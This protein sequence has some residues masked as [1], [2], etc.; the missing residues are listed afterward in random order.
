MIMKTL[1]FGFLG[2]G[3]VPNQ[4]SA[5]YLTHHQQHFFDGSDVER[6]VFET[7]ALTPVPSKN[8]KKLFWAFASNVRQ[9]SDG[10]TATLLTNL[11]GNTPN[12]SPFE[13]NWAREYFSNSGWD[14]EVEDVNFETRGLMK[15]NYI[16]CGSIKK[17]KK[18]QGFMLRVTA[19]GNVVTARRYQDIYNL[20]SCI[21]NHETNGY[22]AVGQTQPRKNGLKDA[23]YVNVKKNLKPSCGLNMTGIFPE[24]DFFGLQQESGF[25][26]VIPYSRKGYQLYAAVGETASNSFSDCEQNSDVLVALVHEGCEVRWVNR[27]GSQGEPALKKTIAERGLSIAQFDTSE[28]GLVITGKTTATYGCDDIAFD[29][30]LIFKLQEDGSIVNWMGHYSVEHDVSNCGL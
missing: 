21:P 4:A 22:V 12:T 29:N 3:L 14:L 23:V 10:D 2:L 5:Q 25:N 24:Q 30:I 26:K 20:K 11:K 27:Y 19:S 13:F 17:G 9:N 16:L 28:G 7:K 15:R 6:Q 1:F 8:E 18:S